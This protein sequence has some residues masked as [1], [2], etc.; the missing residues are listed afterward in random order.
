MV[1][2]GSVV[3]DS[4]V[5]GGSVVRDSVVIGGSVVGDSVVIGGSVVGASV[6][7][8]GSFVEGL[9]V[10]IVTSVNCDS[11]VAGAPIHIFFFYRK[12]ITSRTQQQ[13]FRSR[14]QRC[15]SCCSVR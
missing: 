1:I 10:G 13:T 9:I 5:I 14:C 7:I 15:W 6:V 8:R 4:V 2:G 11:V 3:G 12:S